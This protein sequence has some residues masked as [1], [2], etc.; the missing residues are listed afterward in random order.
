MVQR[1]QKPV[2]PTF[3]GSPV[4]IPNSDGAGVIIILTSALSRVP[5]NPDVSRSKPGETDADDA[6]ADTQR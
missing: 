6:A 4:C 1:R 5:A 2:V 3:N